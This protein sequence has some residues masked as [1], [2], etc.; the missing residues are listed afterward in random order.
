MFFNVVF[1]SIWREW[2]TQSVDFSKTHPISDQRDLR[3][4]SVFIHKCKNRRLLTLSETTLG[5]KK[6]DFVVGTMDE[7]LPAKARDTD[8]IPSLGRFR[9]L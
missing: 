3:D 1:V 6:W 2:V 4:S 8:S 5:E 7:N 9:M